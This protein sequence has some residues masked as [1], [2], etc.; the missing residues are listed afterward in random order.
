MDFLFPGEFSDGAEGMGLTTHRGPLM[1]LLGGLCFKLFGA[2]HQAIVGM[3][4]VLL[5]LSALGLHLVVKVLTGRASLGLLVAAAF[6]G[7][8]EVIHMS[9]TL[10]L[11][12]A[13][14]FSTVM[15]LLGLVAILRGR[16]L[17]VLG[18]SLGLSACL[19]S[20]HVMLVLVWVPLVLCQLGPW[21]RLVWSRPRLS[22]GLIL[23]LPLL[24]LVLGVL[25]EWSPSE[26]KGSVFLWL[27]YGL[28][29]AGLAQWADKRR[30]TLE[31][32]DQE[33]ALRIGLAVAAA[34]ATIF[35]WYWSTL[36]Q[37][38]EHLEGSSTPDLLSLNQAMA[39]WFFQGV[40]LCIRTLGPPVFLLSLFGLLVTL[41]RPLPLGRLCQ[42][43]M[44][45]ALI[46]YPLFFHAR[47]LLLLAPFLL[48]LLGMGLA[49]L[50]GRWTAPAL[51]LAMV[52][53]SGLR[54]GGWMVPWGPRHM[55]DSWLYSESTWL[56]GRFICSD[57]Y[58]G[59]TPEV[60]EYILS[61]SVLMTVAPFR[62]VLGVDQIFEAVE[63]H[64]P[65]EEATCGLVYREGDVLMDGLLLMDWP[66]IEYT[67]QFRFPGVVMGGMSRGQVE[68]AVRSHED[69]AARNAWEARAKAR[70]WTV[71]ERIADLGGH[72]GTV[73]RLSR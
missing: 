33:Q 9:H 25:G 62:P 69:A 27:S 15:V 1:Y 48:V 36:P 61:T 39:L 52:V 10:F 59:P 66:L 20:R 42:V 47:Y 63:R 49:R 28:A 4:L 3:N 8:P 14:V 31:S 43:V 12:T 73:T 2:T 68:F 32:P 50:P 38:L 21:A 70:G 54:V 46:G 64:C 35:P 34:C 22:L 37:I 67:D 6:L 23:P 11:E 13:G 29:C 26:T 71:V 72:L 60:R 44:V 40:V 41:W 19:L 30:P 53:W 57:G 5:G 7:S 24:A 51:L 45:V 17:G 56:Y 18:L 55:P 65:A 16:P 58:C